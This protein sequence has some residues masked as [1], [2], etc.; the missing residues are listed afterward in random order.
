[1][2]LFD[3]LLHLLVEWLFFRKLDKNPTYYMLEFFMVSRWR[4][5]LMEKGGFQ[6]NKLSFMVFYRTKGC[7]KTVKITRGWIYLWRGGNHE[8]F[9]EFCGSKGSFLKLWGHSIT[10]W[11]SSGRSHYRE[12]P[13]WDVSNW[14]RHNWKCFLAYNLFFLFFLISYIFDTSKCA[15]NYIIS[16]EVYHCFIGQ[17]ILKL[18]RQESQPFGQNPAQISI[19]VQ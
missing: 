16:F 19:P 7:N 8:P 13:H 5:W 15:T 12:V 11:T 4:E 10:T 18:W 14:A 2:Q 17:K 1:M 6:T 3:I 9:V